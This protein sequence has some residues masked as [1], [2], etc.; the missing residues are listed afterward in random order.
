MPNYCYN[1]LIAYH[2]SKLKLEWLENIASNEKLCET[3]IPIENDDDAWDLWGCKWDIT[4]KECNFDT[5]GN[6]CISFDT[7]WNPPKK[8]IN[9]LISMG[10][11]CQLFYYEPGCNFAGILTDDNDIYINSLPDNKDELY[12]IVPK[13]L[14]YLFGIDLDV[15]NLSDSDEDDTDI[16]E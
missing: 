8:V 14:I 6:L 11:K 16:V 3:I 12:E 10:F 5:K 4:Y 2:E 1:Y 9:K 15:E 7:P 13:K